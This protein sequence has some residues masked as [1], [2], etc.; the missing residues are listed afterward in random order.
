[1]KLL[2]FYHDIEIYSNLVLLVLRGRILV[3]VLPLKYMHMRLHTLL[4]YQD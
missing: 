2:F 1:M 4:T 3:F